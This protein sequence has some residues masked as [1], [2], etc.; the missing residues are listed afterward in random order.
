[1]PFGIQVFDSGGSTTFSTEDVTWNY[2]GSFIAPANQEFYFS[3]PITMPEYLVTRL[4]LNQ[5]TGDDE[6]YVHSYQIVNYW[7]GGWTVRAYPPSTTG[8][9]ATQFVIFGR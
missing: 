4:M 5:A 1:M 9:T 6:A 3:L 8:T 7:F 2:I